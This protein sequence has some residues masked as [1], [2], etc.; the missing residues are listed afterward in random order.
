MFLDVASFVVSLFIASQNMFGDWFFGINKPSKHSSFLRYS[1]FSDF[2]WPARRF[3]PP[4][5]YPGPLCVIGLEALAECTRDFS[6]KLAKFYS[7]EP[8]YSALVIQSLRKQDI[9][10]FEG[11]E[12][13]VEDV[14]PF[15]VI[16]STWSFLMSSMSGLRGLPSV[17]KV[18]I[19]MVFLSG[20]P[21]GWSQ[22][23]ADSDNR[24]TVDVGVSSH[25]CDNF[26]DQSDE[27]ITLHLD[28]CVPLPVHALN[29]HPGTGM[30][31]K[32]DEWLN[33]WQVTVVLI[34]ASTDNGPCAGPLISV[35]WYDGDCTS[36]ERRASG[37]ILFT[38]DTGTPLLQSR[39]AVAPALTSGICSN[40]LPI[41]KKWHIRPS[42][43]FPICQASWA[44]LVHV[45]GIGASI[46]GAF[47][48][49]FNVG[50]PA[51]VSSLE[52]GELCPRVAIMAVGSKLNHDG[53]H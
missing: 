24:P 10:T 44:S 32:T 49:A 18:L 27:G 23:S 8:V 19:I 3:S 20:V 52:H 9:A 5:H 28:E 15:L 41:Q 46:S 6:R 2:L 33:T 4:W 51:T 22:P 53:I 34:Y 11:G 36:Y 14:V 29:F 30:S 25:T 12:A 40:V 38:V 50:V 13:V 7:V 39:L 16:I 37:A 17:F 1:T 43:R 47:N 35:L 21:T 42:Q 26:W 31:V 48:G 45:S